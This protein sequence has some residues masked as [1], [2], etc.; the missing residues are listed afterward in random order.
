MTITCPLPATAA[1]PE[2]EQVGLP[3]MQQEF[4]LTSKTPLSPLQHAAEEMCVQLSGPLSVRAPSPESGL[5]SGHSQAWML[6][7]LSVCACG[8]GPNL[9]LEAVHS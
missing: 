7:L 4:A 6:A 2:S 8:H 1:E 5:Q 3:W 9:Q